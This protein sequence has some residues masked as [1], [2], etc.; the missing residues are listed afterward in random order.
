VCI[1][2]RSGTSRLVKRWTPLN[3]RCGGGSWLAGYLKLSNPPSRN[4]P[5]ATGTRCYCRK[6]EEKS[7][8]QQYRPFQERTPAGTSTAISGQTRTHPIWQA[9][10]AFNG[11]TPF[12]TQL[13]GANTRADIGK[14][15]AWHFMEYGS[16]LRVGMNG[17]LHSK[18]IRKLYRYE[19]VFPFQRSNRTS[20]PGSLTLLIHILEVPDW[21]TWNLML[22]I[23]S[24]LN[25]RDQVPHQHKTSIPVSWIL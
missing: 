25:I 19:V 10:V 14:N 9:G 13:L 15:A 4:L 22:R 18:G 16:F 8:H 12:R 1:R 21:R 3:Y 20:W 5:A 24:S 11:D 2:F 7:L 23:Y 17:I 6:V